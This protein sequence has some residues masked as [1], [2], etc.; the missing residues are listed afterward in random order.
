L[1]VRPQ[2][3][4]R[5]DSSN[6]AA[7][8]GGLV[9]GLAFYAA[10]A[11]PLRRKHFPVTWDPRKWYLLTVSMLGYSWLFAGEKVMPIFTVRKASGEDAGGW[12]YPALRFDLEELYKKLHRDDPDARVGT[13]AL[14]PGLCR[15]A[16][17]GVEYGKFAL[18]ADDRQCVA[19]CTKV[20]VDIK[21]I[22]TPPCTYLFH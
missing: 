18:M 11:M 14:V 3:K 4:D 17:R 12:R 20:G 13:A 8:V 5:N 10:V 22:R 16:G 2:D 21:V 7:H 19:L 6:H 1:Q 9:A 15:I